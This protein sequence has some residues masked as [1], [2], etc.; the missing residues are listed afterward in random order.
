MA[1]KARP[2]ASPPDSRSTKRSAGARRPNAQLVDRRGAKRV[3]RRQH[4]PAAVGGE[5]RGKLADSGGLAGAVDADH[6]DHERP[7]ARVDVERPG[8]GEERP[9][10]LGGKHALDFVGIDSLIVAPATDRLANARRRAKAEVGLNEDI[11]EIVERC[12]VELALGE[13]VDDS[14]PDVCRGAREGESKALKPA[15]LRL[16]RRRGHLRRELRR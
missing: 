8:D 13:D 2:A 12:G 9:L 6:Q 1:S 10:D 15:S 14:A 5:L 4:H 7:L 16:Q 11:L 3:P